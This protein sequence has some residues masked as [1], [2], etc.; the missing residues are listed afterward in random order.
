MRRQ[1]E[2]D[3]EKKADDEGDKDEQGVSASGE[4]CGQA[5]TEAEERLWG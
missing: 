4:S 5:E 3:Q 2:E 1:G